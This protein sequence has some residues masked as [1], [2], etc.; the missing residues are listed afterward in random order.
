V[1]LPGGEGWKAAA[2]IFAFNDPLS[3][4]KRL[5]RHPALHEKSAKLL[6]RYAEGGDRAN[7]RLLH[8]IVQAELHAER[9]DVAPVVE[10]HARL[11]APGRA[12][13]KRA[14]EVDVWIDGD[15]SRHISTNEGRWLRAPRYVKA[16]GRSGFDKRMTKAK[17]RKKSK[18]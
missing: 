16:I 8:D 13:T 17:K 10:S 3:R 11:G 14:V 1:T 12:R 7:D 4:I 2:E 6:A 5:Q 18:R 9:M 15:L